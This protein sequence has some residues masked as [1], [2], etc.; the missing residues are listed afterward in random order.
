MRVMACWRCVRLRHLRAHEF[1]FWLSYPPVT[2]KSQFHK[3]MDFAAPIGTLFMP[4]YSGNGVVTFSGWGTGYG[5]YVA[6]G[7][8]QRYCHALRTY[9]CK[10]C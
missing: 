8:W 3:G 4:P 2:G 5:R 6:S 1:R 9:L 7:S 10:L